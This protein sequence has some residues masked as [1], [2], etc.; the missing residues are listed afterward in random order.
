MKVFVAGGAGDVG[1][2]VVRALRARDVAVRAL[3]RS[4][5]VPG[6]ENVRGDLADRASLDPALAG[7][8]AAIFITPHH[9]H[10]EQLG[11]NLVEAARGAAGNGLRRLVFISAFHPTSR[12]LVVQRVLDGI[13]GLVGPHYRAK[14]RVERLVR[15]A[16]ELSPVVLNPSNFYQNDELC[17][18]EILEGRYP[19]CLGQKPANRVDTRD[20]G[21]AAAIAVTTDLPSGAY[22]LVGPG[23][24]TG[25]RCAEVWADALGTPVTYAGDDVAT[26]AATVGARM[27][28]ARSAD[29]QKTLRI[30]Q[31]YGIP[32]SKRAIAETTAVLG[33]PP[34]DYR[35]YVVERAAQLR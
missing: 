15:A 8:D 9:E 29:F 19:Q 25:D 31:R 28:A 14:L 33:R 32:A 22:A 10:E 20:I 13:L 30:I 24:W 16:R 12:S 4:Q 5:P 6:T 23:P 7:C 11:T 1:T 34:R 17:L 2:E 18:P 21:E 35:S 27:P 3:V 26:W